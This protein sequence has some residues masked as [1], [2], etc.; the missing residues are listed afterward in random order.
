M[1][2]VAPSRGEKGPAASRLALFDNSAELFVARL[3]G[4]QSLLQ[5]SASRQALGIDARKWFD[6]RGLDRNRFPKVRIMGVE[7]KWFTAELRP[8][9]ELWEC[10]EAL[11]ALRRGDRVVFYCEHGKHR[12]FQLALYVLSPFLGVRGRRQLYQ[13][14]APGGRGLPST[15]VVASCRVSA[16]GA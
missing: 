3:D 4:A 9:A 11:A 10:L 13:D 6:P 5:A 7:A 8:P 15:Q 1:V 12:S 2:S 14:E 16:V